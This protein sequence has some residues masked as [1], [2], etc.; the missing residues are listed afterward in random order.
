MRP[1][2]NFLFLTPR[3]VPCGWASTLAGAWKGV[4]GER[5]S[6]LSLGGAF[7]T[8]FGTLPFQR[9]RPDPR[10]AGAVAALLAQGA[11]CCCASASGRAEAW[12]LPSGHLTTS[13]RPGLCSLVPPRIAGPMTPWC[14]HQVVRLS[15]ATWR[16]EDSHTDLCLRGGCRG[17][18]PGLSSS[19][20]ADFT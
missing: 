3:K 10:G 20:W 9:V 17:G 6:N 4:R 16:G 15:E 7:G 2:E 11:L 19:L 1:E 12:S 5:E 8:P 18:G 13:L 14:P